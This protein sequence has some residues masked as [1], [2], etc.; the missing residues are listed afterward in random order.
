MNTA[1]IKEEG[2]GGTILLTAMNANASNCD[3]FVSPRFLLFGARAAL[4]SKPVWHCAVMSEMSGLRVNHSEI[5][6]RLLWG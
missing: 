2:I 4:S 3:V 5:V 1:T 6:W